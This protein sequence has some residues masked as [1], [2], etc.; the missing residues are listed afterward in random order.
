MLRHPIE[1]PPVKT[2]DSF[3]SFRDAHWEVFPVRLAKRSHT[4]LTPIRGTIVGGGRIRSIHGIPPYSL[5][6]INRQHLL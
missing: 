6:L 5:F 1:Q 4:H 3:L 2:V